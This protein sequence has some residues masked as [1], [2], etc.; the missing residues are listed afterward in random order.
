MLRRQRHRSRKGPFHRLLRILFNDDGSS[1]K[2]E[3]QG[4]RGAPIPESIATP[5][6]LNELVKVGIEPDSPEAK[7]QSLLKARYIDKQVYRIG[8]WDKNADHGSG[9]QM[10]F[11]IRQPEPYSI[12]R[13]Q[14]AIELTKDHIMFHDL[15]GRYGTV[16]DGARVGGRPNTPTSVRLEKGEH[17]LV[18]GPR[19]SI[20]RFKLIVQ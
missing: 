18:F 11:L 3:I 16:V 12:S 2:L 6:V 15:G 1:S 9:P 10:D 7:R 14:C 4:G 13:S 8:R 20:L 17:T 19:N 5:D